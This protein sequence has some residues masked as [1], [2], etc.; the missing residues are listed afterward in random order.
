MYLACPIRM[1]GTYC[2][3]SNNVNTLDVAT[4]FS[5]SCQSVEKL[6]SFIRAT[7][8]SLRKFLRLRRPNDS[9]HPARFLRSGASP[10]YVAPFDH[11]C[12]V[13]AQQYRRNEEFEPYKCGSFQCTAL[14][15]TLRP[16][17]FQKRAIILVDLLA[18]L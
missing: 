12:V 18:F 14:C 2:S 11:T 17:R 15:S 8:F 5:H 7:Q 3:G 13:I 1:L 10:S 9:D 4:S 6:F 16:R